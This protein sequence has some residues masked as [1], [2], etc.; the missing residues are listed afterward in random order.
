MYYAFGSYRAGSSARPTFRSVLVLVEHAAS[1]TSGGFGGES[2]RYA[3]SSLC[4]PR[5]APGGLNNDDGALDDARHAR[6]HAHDR[7]RPPSAP[8]HRRGRGGNAARAS[9]RALRSRLDSTRVPPAPEVVAEAL[10]PRPTEDPTFR[11]TFGPGVALVLAPVRRRYGDPLGRKGDTPFGN[12]EDKDIERIDRDGLV[13]G[14]REDT[15]F[16]WIYEVS[17]DDGDSDELTWPELLLVLTSPHQ[18]ASSET[19]AVADAILALSPEERAAAVRALRASGEDYLKRTLVGYRT[20]KLRRTRGEADVYLARVKDAAGTCVDFQCHFPT[21]W[22]A[23]AAHDLLARALARY[24]SGAADETINFP[25]NLSYDTL[26]GVVLGGADDSNWTA[27]RTRSR[28]DDMPP[29]RIGDARRKRSLADRYDPGGFSRHLA[30]RQTTQPR[31]RRPARPGFESGRERRYDASEEHRWGHERATRVWSR[32][33][34]RERTGGGDRE[35]IREDSDSRRLR[36]LRGRLLLPVR[37]VRIRVR[38]RVVR[39]YVRLLLRTLLRILL[40]R[41][42]RNH[43]REALLRQPRRKKARIRIQT[44][45][46]DGRGGRGFV[47]ASGRTERAAAA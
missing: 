19:R 16:G 30:A 45:S 22:G 9:A 44:R 37:R 21:R 26:L 12:D 46:L 41:R 18:H 2:T 35:R 47:A 3:S 32:R 38:I 24:G 14:F 28:Q 34:G 42:C 4:A 31:R 33:I 25:T 39:L 36:H 6:G 10:R 40:F 17:Y 27:A 5:D 7:A 8:S 29:P 20:F 23:A 11:P 15:N 43:R 13:V 1:V